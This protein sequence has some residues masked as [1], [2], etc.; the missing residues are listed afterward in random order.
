MTNTELLKQRIEESGLKY[1][2]IAEKLGLSRFGLKKKIDND[3]SFKA[4]EIQKMCE[5][6]FLTL[7]EREEIFFASNVGK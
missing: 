5:V 2:F 1:G 3:S 7:E 4:E 6:L